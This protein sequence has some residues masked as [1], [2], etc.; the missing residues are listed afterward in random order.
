VQVQVREAH[1]RELIEHAAPRLRQQLAEL[2]V[3]LGEVTVK[4]EGAEGQRQRHHAASAEP[5]DDE[6]GEANASTAQEP[7]R[8]AA[9]RSASPSDSIRPG[10]L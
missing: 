7:T 9:S 4:E 5:H 1:T 10:P 8:H 2:G 6:A 3:N